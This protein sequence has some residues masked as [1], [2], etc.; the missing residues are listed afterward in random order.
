M[1]KTAVA[2]KSTTPDK[3]EGAAVR[4]R[5]RVSRRIPRNREPEW[6]EIFGDC[7]LTQDEREALGLCR[8]T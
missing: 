4:L 8:K 6:A 7:A 5:V 1:A 2:E 3:P